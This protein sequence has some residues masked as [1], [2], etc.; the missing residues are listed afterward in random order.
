MEIGHRRRGRPKAF[1]GAKSP[2]AI[3]SLNRALDAL[4]VLASSRGL[5]L[6]ELAATLDQSVA[7]MHRVLATLERRG[8]VEISTDRQEWYVGA[9]AFRIGS[10]FLRQTNVVE[11]SRPVMRALMQKTGETCNLGIEKNG[12][13]LFISQVETHESIRAFFPPGTLAPLHASGIGKAL[14]STY[15]DTR[16]HALIR[17]ATLERFTE[18]TMSSLGKLQEELHLTR[19][20]GYA[21]DDEERAKG[22]RCVAAPI[23][24]LHGEAVAG[25]SISG[26]TQRLLDSQVHDIGEFVKKGAMEI[27]GL[28]GAH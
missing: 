19:K 6:T 27:S 21:L 17:N 18:K 4:A 15:N 16:L 8:F 3:K 14:L 22:M 24:N 2:T 26:P 28:L 9:G 25:I 23:L 13:V 12:N 11:R 10:A 7:T 20:R 1:A 5:T